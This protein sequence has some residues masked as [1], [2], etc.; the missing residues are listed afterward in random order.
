LPSD[1]VDYR[2][3]ESTTSRHR[4]DEDADVRGRLSFVEE[5][6]D[7]EQPAAVND[8][9]CERMLDIDVRFL[10]GRCAR[11]SVQC[12]QKRTVRFSENASSRVR[13]AGACC[14][15]I[16]EESN[17]SRAL[18]NV[19]GIDGRVGFCECDFSWGGEQTRSTG[20]TQC[21]P[22]VRGK[23]SMI[24]DDDEPIAVEFPGVDP[25]Q[26]APE[27]EHALL[28]VGVEELR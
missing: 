11:L 23:V 9:D 20:G 25:E 6:C 16:V 15:A 24:R 12:M 14:F 2:C 18:P 27:R 26:A 7:S 13:L 22:P 4:G 1:L 8:P 19:G 3:A 17:A 10:G 21:R 28:E 5:R